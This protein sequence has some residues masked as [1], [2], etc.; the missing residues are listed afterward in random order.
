MTK[1]WRGKFQSRKPNYMT[2]FDEPPTYFD[3]KE[4]LLQDPQLVRFAASKRFVQFAVSE[5]NHGDGQWKAVIMA[6]MNDG[7]YWCTGYLD[8]IPPEDWF[9]KWENPD[10]KHE[11]LEDP[12]LV[13]YRQMLKEKEDRRRAAHMMTTNELEMV[14]DQIGCPAEIL[15]TVAWRLRQYDKATE[16][17][18]AP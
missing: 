6:D 17:N 8:F 3:T 7:T 9:P 1:I 14:L 5:W 2:G 13:A 15:E 4:Q 11:F 10:Q 16:R 12:E 18:K